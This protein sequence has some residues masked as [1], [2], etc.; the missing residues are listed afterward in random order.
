MWACVRIAD[1]R[2][3]RVYAFHGSLCL[4]ARGLCLCAPEP[5]T[6]NSRSLKHCLLSCPT[7]PAPAVRRPRVPRPPL[8]LTPTWSPHT[9][10]RSRASRDGG[11]LCKHPAAPTRPGCPVCRGSRPGLCAADHGQRSHG[12]TKTN[13]RAPCSQ[14][15]GPAKGRS[16]SEQA[17]VGRFVPSAPRRMHSNPERAAPLRWNPCKT[18]VG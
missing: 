13:P 3:R 2:V 11:R 17:K 5:P 8:P 16:D 7:F 12:V 4:L 18:A 14:D 1:R 6:G 15:P 9:P 10:S